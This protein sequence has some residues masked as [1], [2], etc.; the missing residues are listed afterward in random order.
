[1]RF[2]PFKQPTSDLWKKWRKDCKIETEKIC[3]KADANDP[4]D[5]PTASSIYKRDSIRRS[6]YFAID[7]PFY[8][9]CAYCE[10]YLRDYERPDIDHFRPKGAVKKADGAPALVNDVEHPGYYWLSYDAENL[11]P[12][13]QICNQPTIIDGH[14]IGKHDYFPI[15]RE[16]VVRELGTP[17]ESPP[18]CDSE[19]PLLLNP[20]IDYP[21]EHLTVETSTGIM[22]AKTERGQTCIDM[23]GLNIRDQLVDDRK[24]AIN[25][26]KSLLSEYI[27]NPATRAGTLKEMER[28]LNGQKRA[29]L[30]SQSVAIELAPITDLFDGLK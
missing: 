17:Y 5:P 26:F 21:E 24:T 19:E 23:F 7:G 9:K 30:A 15:K 3:L 4:N 16:Y 27:H 29:T 25:N 6:V 11:L 14:K 13:C 2:I 12:A 22:V 18:A 10:C 20:L 28:I 8:G 1:M